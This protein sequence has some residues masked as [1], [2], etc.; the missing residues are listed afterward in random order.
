MLPH[1]GPEIIEVI[2]TACSFAPTDS[3]N[4]PRPTFRK[5]DERIIPAMVLSF[6]M[7]YSNS[8]TVGVLNV[9][10]QWCP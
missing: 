6:T 2:K 1:L 8:R 5:S 9:W 4:G 7:R 3:R 10:V